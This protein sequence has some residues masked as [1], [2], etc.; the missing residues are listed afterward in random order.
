MN[1]ECKTNES[2]EGPTSQVM[3]IFEDHFRGLGAC[4]RYLQTLALVEPRLKRLAHGLTAQQS[5]VLFG[6]ELTHIN[7]PTFRAL[8]ERITQLERLS[9]VETG[10][11]AHGTNSSAL[12]ARIV[13][14]RGGVFTTIDLNSQA[15]GNAA[16]LFRA[17]G[18][19]GCTAICGDSV[20]TLRQLD[21]RFNIVYLDSYDLTPEHFLQSEWH[22]LA[23]FQ[24]LLERGSLD[25]AESYILIDDTPRSIEIFASQVDE[26]YLQKVREHV[27]R[28][29]RL[30][31]KGALIAEAVRSNASFEVLAWEYQLLLRYRGA[32]Q[33]PQQAR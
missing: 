31:G 32:T 28:F 24:V 17:I 30:P 22:G 8:C 9:I 7:Y 4:D 15:S 25:E 12:F 3:A 10:S 19:P 5:A 20:Q 27:V 18:A 14:Q 26:Y 23:E 33:E 21:Q 13:A 1:V 16:Q 29:G 2:R 11:S 6:A